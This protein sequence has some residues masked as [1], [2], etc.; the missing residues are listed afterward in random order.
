MAKKRKEPPSPCIDVCKYERK[1]RCIGCSM[2]KRQKAAFK[3]LTREADRLAFLETI[4]RQLKAQGGYRAWAKIYRRKCR[5]K[6]AR[7]PLDKLG[8]K[9]A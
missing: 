9:A 6:G 2:T 1:G 3:S 5:K 4:L 8:A 7:C